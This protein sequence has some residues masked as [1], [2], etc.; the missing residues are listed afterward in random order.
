MFSSMDV[1][2][3]LVA[4]VWDITINVLLNDPTGDIILAVF[5]L[6]VTFIVAKR[7][8]LNRR[9]VTLNILQVLVGLIGWTVLGLYYL[10][11]VADE[12]A[13]GYPE[14]VVIAYTSLLCLCFCISI[15]GAALIVRYASAPFAHIRADIAGGLIRLADWVSDTK[16]Y[17]EQRARV[18]AVTKS[19]DLVEAVLQERSPHPSEGIG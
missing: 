19:I 9:R 4:R 2:M 18:V 11:R 8:H 13:I 14:L 6:G 7:N 1:F 5:V 16:H 17:E 3:L 12:T 10:T 15:F